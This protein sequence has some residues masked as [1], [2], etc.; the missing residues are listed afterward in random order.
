[1]S[2]ENARRILQRESQ[3]HLFRPLT[4]RSVETRNRIMMSPMCQYSARDGLA[5]DWHFA[6]LAARAVGGAG[7]VC[8]EACHV[9]PRGRITKHCLGLWNDQQRDRLARIVAFVTAQGAVPAIQL[10][11][12]GR[13]GSVSRP[14]EGTQPLTA[15]DG[16]W[17]VICPSH[18][19]FG[20]RT[21]ALR[22]MDDA[23]IAEV[24]AAFKSATR[25]AREAGF[26]I[27]ELHAAHG[28]LINEFLAASSNQRTDRY[29]GSFENRARLLFETIDA[30]REEW[31]TELPL[32]VRLSVTEWVPGGWDIEDTIHL[33][34]M[35]KDHGGVDLIDCS[36]GGNDPGQRLPTHPGYQVPYAERV[37]QET[38]IAT[39]AV[40]LISSPEA[41][42]EII[43]NGRADLVALGRILLF[44]PYWPLHAANALKA[45][46][47]PWPLQ[48]ERASIF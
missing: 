38:G 20:N 43:A 35:L 8:V 27:L 26:K 45:K 33:C 41:A 3:P 14:W 7:I 19:P 15:A 36:S 44:D 23:A 12:S 6:H 2:T 48:Y 16:A 21:T 46:T 40:G 37:R 1:M 47:V 4:L 25:R 9:E 10:A 34:R 31:P 30:I 39:A 42:E 18:V 32:F 13:K 22:A 28:Y 24:I 5:D 17:E 29:G 11:H